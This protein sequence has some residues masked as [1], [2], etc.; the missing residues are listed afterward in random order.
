MRYDH[1]LEFI[2]IPMICTERLILRRIKKSD[3]TDVNE[4]SRDPRVSEYLLWYPH[5]S[6]ATTRRYLKSVDK[7]YKTG[8]FYTWGI[9]Y[10]GK[11]IGTVGFNCFSLEH[12]TAEVGYVLSADYWGR[13]IATEALSRIVEYAFEHLALNRL[14]IKYINENSASLAV[15]LHCG[16]KKEG[17]MRQAMCVKGRYRDIGIAAMTADD[18]RK[19]TKS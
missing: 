5:T 13:G 6:V 2:N 9:E 14:E 16:F 8:E 19:E 4:Y 15:A 11:L 17:V 18:Y 1:L 12:G 3:L 10:K 7:K